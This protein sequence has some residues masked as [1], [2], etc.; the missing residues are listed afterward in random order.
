[1]KADLS[2]LKETG[3]SDSF[4]LSVLRVA[5]KSGE[6]SQKCF[7]EKALRFAC[8]DEL[9]RSIEKVRKSKF[10]KLLS[11]GLQYGSYPALLSMATCDNM[12][13]PS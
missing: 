11:V 2:T 5:V 10:Q 1:M 4:L 6:S 9:A 12:C 13:P 3:P 7:P 8:L